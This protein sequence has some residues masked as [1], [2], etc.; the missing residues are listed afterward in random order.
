MICCQFIF[1]PGTYDQDFPAEPPG[2]EGPG[3]ALVRRIPHRRQRGHR[4]VRRR[5]PRPAGPGG[6]GH[7]C[8]FSN[9]NCSRTDPSIG[10]I[11]VK[12]LGDHCAGDEEQ[13]VLALDQEVQA[14][15]AVVEGLGLGRRQRGL[16]DV[17]RDAV[18]PLAGVHDDRR[19]PV[20]AQRQLLSRA[21]ARPLR[22]RRRRPEDVGD[23]DQGQGQDDADARLRLR[24]DQPADPGAEQRQPRTQPHDEWR[25]QWVRRPVLQERV[26]EQEQRPDGEQ[27]PP[28]QLDEP[29]GPVEPRQPLA[30]LAG[31]GLVGVRARHRG[32]AHA[33]AEHVMSDRDHD[34]DQDEDEQRGEQGL[35]AA[36]DVVLRAQADRVDVDAEVLELRT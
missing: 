15:V 1:K 2:G 23:Q 27:A 11:S 5:P 18:Q 34:A 10:S 30:S 14:P 8:A 9:W 20:Q 24:V 28:R 12:S 33:P 17:G 26:P 19:Q 4:D 32:R 6:G 22:D 13:P 16:L 25:H 21:P 3:P 35:G 36:H 7:G 29:E 31:D